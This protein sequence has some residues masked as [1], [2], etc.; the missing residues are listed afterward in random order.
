MN[1]R[2]TIKD[3]SELAGVSLGTVSNYINRT[4]PISAATRARIEAA[5]EQ[6]H[7]VPNRTVR[8]LRGN[9]SHAVGLLVPDA[10]NPFFAEMARGVDAV[11]RQHGNLLIYCDT[12][13]DPARQRAY[14]R[15][16]AGMR[17]GGMI[18]SSSEVTAEDMRE[19]DF[20]ATPIV[21]VGQLELGADGPAVLV[22]QRS[23]G[24]LAM[25]HLLDLGHRRIAF[26][27]GPGGV[28]VLDARHSGVLLAAEEA[29]VPLDAVVRIDASGR[30]VQERSELAGA[31]AA[32][33]PRP[34]AVICGNDLI[35]I[36]I[37]NRLVRDGW[38]IPD[39]LAIVGYDDIGEAQLAVVPLTTVR[40]PAYEI[41][42]SAARLLFSQS[43]TG[44][45]TEQQILYRPELVVRES[46]VGSRHPV[47]PRFSG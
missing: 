36:A 1:R 46:T 13:G 25:K 28:A 30:S 20:L 47:I 8:T 15:D 38:S 41:G 26:A 21:V 22:D 44:E 11:A 4:K 24:Y 6:T 27:G 16:L 43:D 34:T 39:D 33:Q 29:G 45:H 40:Q 23:G 14:V 18:V 2:A 35:A 7:F 12:E 5:I 10:A 19:L 9:S 37:L 31:I 3:V 32:L 17:V 42:A